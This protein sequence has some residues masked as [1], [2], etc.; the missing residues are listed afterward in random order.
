M[1]DRRGQSMM[2]SAYLRKNRLVLIALPAILAVA[3]SFWAFDASA[4]DSTET[5]KVEVN[6][7]MLYFPVAWAGW[8]AMSGAQP[9]YDNHKPRSDVIYRTTS[10]VQGN[11]ATRAW[12]EGRVFWNT[13]LWP[14]FRVTAIEISRNHA[15]PFNQP[16]SQAFP[17]GWW[18]L[19]TQVDPTR[20]GI[21][22]VSCQREPSQRR[23]EFGTYA[24]LGCGVTR[25]AA[26]GLS[27]RYQWN[28]L[29]V[30]EQNEREQDRR[31][32]HLVQWL[33]MPPDRRSS[34]P[35]D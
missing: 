3:A 10:M 14:D 13:D 15:E 20:E 1:E 27:I 33:L 2:L 35:I 5:I 16:L 24:Y 31:V 21:G 34:R 32:Q 23:A 29:E 25:R 30:G 4:S 22:L 8:L 6:G 28:R 17:S 11:R 19:P 9:T 7:R 12:N 18:P 26:D